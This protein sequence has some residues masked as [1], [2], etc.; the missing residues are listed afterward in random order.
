MPDKSK[1]LNAMRLLEKEGIPYDV[2][3]FSPEIH[4]AV[5]LAAAV[6]APPET[7]FKTLV[8]TRPAGKP[9]LVMIPG[10][11]TLD[12]KALAAAIGE[13]KLAMATHDE[14][15]KLTGLKV[16]GIGALALTHKGWDVLLDESAILYEHI[17]VSAG[18]RGI[19]LKVPVEGL[20]RALGAKVVAVARAPD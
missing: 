5:E 15:E 16:G 2:I 10:P 6:G 9:L 18:Q 12:L 4:S 17:L 3:E 20:I 1:K 7:V 14:A 19:N 13:K 11:A 8:V